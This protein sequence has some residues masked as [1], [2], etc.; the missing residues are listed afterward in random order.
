MAKKLSGKEARAGIRRITKHCPNCGAGFAFSGGGAT[1]ETSLVIDAFVRMLG[2]GEV[3][4]GCIEN[5]EEDLRQG[6]SWIHP[7]ALDGRGEEQ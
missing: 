3:L 5:M 4:I 7:L 1:R 2:R 6:R